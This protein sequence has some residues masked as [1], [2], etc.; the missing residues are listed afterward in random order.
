MKPVTQTRFGEPEG[1]CFAACVASILEC[2]LTDIPDLLDW[3]KDRNW[4]EWFNDGLAG[5]GVGVFYAAASPA[6]PFNGYIPNGGHFIASGPGP[7]GLLHSVVMQAQPGKLDDTGAVVNQLNELAHDPNPTGDGILE[8]NSI[9]L[10][11]KL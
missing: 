7:R 11:L 10:V 3:P 4:L 9:C 1:N 8:V 2:S 5:K 6:E